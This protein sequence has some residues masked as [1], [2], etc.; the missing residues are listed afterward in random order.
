MYLA[1]TSANLNPRGE[2]PQSNLQIS[3]VRSFEGGLNVT[4]TDLNM[5][6][7]YSKVL[8]NLERNIDGSLALRPGT[9]FV[10]ALPD[11]ANILNCYYFN[12]FVI[13][14]QASGHVTKAAGDG[15]VT[16]MQRDG[17]LP[18]P[19]GS[20]EV[21]FTIFNSDLIIVNGRDKP[22]IIS[23]HAT[24]PDG[25]ANPNYMQV[26]FLVDLG[27]LNN[28]NTPV[29]KFVVA[30]S[31]FTCIAGVAAHPSTLY[32]SMQGTSG[33]WRTET[34][35]DPGVDNNAIA[36]DLGPR[37]SLGSATITGLVA[38]R[39]KLLVTFER[40]VLPLNLGVFAPAVGTSPAVHTPTDD[41]FIEEFGCLTHRSLISVGDD[42]F[43]A[44][45]VGVN[46]IN[47]VNVFNTLRPVRASHLIDPLITAA[48]QAL[49]PAQ[50][51]QYVFAVYDLRN[52]RYMLF[53]PVFSGVTLVETLC[54]SYT[55]IPALKVEAWARLRGWKW[56]A[57]CRTSLQN[58]IFAG[59]NKLYAYDF[60]NASG[61]SDLRN[62]PSVNSGAG[63]PLTFEWEM[64]WADFKHRMDIKQTRYIALDTQGT[65]TFKCEAFIDNIIAWQG[66]DQPMLSM[67]FAGGDSG[68]YGNVPYGD[69]GY[70]GG[71]RSSDERLY[72]WTTKFKLLKLRFSGTTTL[73]L[74]FIS[75]SIAYIHGGIRR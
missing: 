42:T 8:D 40:G 56:Q 24:R 12:N 18:W 23:G 13:S 59:G 36:L 11:G 62:D 22:L 45:N 2:Q 60:N 39:D 57:A 17:A 44:D 4:D 75:V 51:G 50:I 5:S 30:H 47:R 63:L 41:G 21:N 61:G 38:Y 74:K 71:R 29:G 15:T 7:K 48:I 26:Q 3:T 34:G 66:V 70:G 46:S 69:S 35:F 52:F 73:K 31:Q 19:P 28:V 68:G 14:V 54:F 53:V 27:T 58:V 55:H 37:V 20:T 1:K 10:A 9:V 6:P 32:I 67:T 43:Y 72:A 16:D 65:A 33:T 64:P 25:S 49:T